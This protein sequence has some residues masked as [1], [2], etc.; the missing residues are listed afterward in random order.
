MIKKIHFLPGMTMMDV[1]VVAV[2]GVIIYAY[3]RLLTLIISMLV[4]S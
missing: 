1:L 3:I 4:E 2:S